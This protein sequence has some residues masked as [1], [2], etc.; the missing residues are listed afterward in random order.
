MEVSLKGGKLEILSCGDVA[1]LD[2]RHDFSKQKIQE[3]EKKKIG[4][5][6]NVS[7]I[8]NAIRSIKFSKYFSI[9]EKK[10][11]IRRKR[12]RAKF[13]SFQDLPIDKI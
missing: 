6:R 3:N 9:T 13:D 11:E 8:I 5:T 10:K 1:F 7:T 4:K 12:I 2:S